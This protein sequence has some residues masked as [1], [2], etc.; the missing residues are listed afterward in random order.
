MTADLDP[1]AADIGPV[2]ATAQGDPG[3]G[4]PGFTV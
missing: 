4:D 2:I 1:P 3:P